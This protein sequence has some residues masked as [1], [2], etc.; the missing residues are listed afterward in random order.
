MDFLTASVEGHDAKNLAV[1]SRGNPTFSLLRW[2]LARIFTAIFF[3]ILFLWTYNAEGGLGLVEANLFG[4]HALGMSLFVLICTQEGILVFTD[5]PLF[6][7]LIA[8]RTTKTLIHIV[9][10]F[11]GILLAT[12][13]LVAIVYYKNL[14][15]DPLVFPFYHVYSPHSWVG[16]VILSL[17]IIQLATKLAGAPKKYHVFL[18]KAIYLAGLAACAMGLQDMQSSDLASSSTP[19]QVANATMSMSGMEMAGYLP[20]SNLAQ[21]AAGGAIVLLF[22]GIATFFVQL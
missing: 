20:N 7:T 17:W 2:I 22:Q 8:S 15:G 12:G 18:G 14:S 10:H 6:G 19:D 21:Y 3:V 4:L 16:I 11:T 5:V 1:Q 13:A 9:L